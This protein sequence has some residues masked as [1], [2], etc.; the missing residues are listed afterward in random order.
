MRELSAIAHMQPSPIRRIY[1]K[2]ITMDD[3]VFFS[4]G[5]PDFRTPEAVIEEAVCS[6]RDGETHYTSNA[7]I[8][9]LRKAISENLL[10]Y[11]HVAYD[12]DGEICVTSG[13]M[14]ALLLSLLV[15]TDPGDEVIL[16]DPS[17]TNYRD[18]IR[19]AKAVPRY[20]RVREEDGF[21]FRPE[22]LEQAITEKTRVIMLNTPANPTGGV[23]SEKL[24]KQ[25]ADIAIKHDLWILFDEVYKYLFYGNEPFCSM[26]AILG[27]RER[28]LVIDSTSKTY[29]MTGWIAGP[30]EIVSNIPKVQENVCSCVPAFVQRGAAYALRNCAADVAE[31]NR[32]YRARRDLIWSGINEIPKLSAVLPDGAFYLFVNISETGLTSEDFASRLLEEAHVALAPGSAFGPSGEG[33]VRISY[34]CSLETIAEGVRRIRRFIDKL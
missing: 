26:A 7:G 22:D 14:E 6:L 9:D 32:Q 25:I 3:V 12:P 15:L 18:Q 34:A 33:F 23:A 4:I 28:T 1:E 17:Y 30:R 27:M 8:A 16:A 2:A 10:A 13:G 11:D 29:A 24:L 20:V 21:N 5:E 19:I 31:M